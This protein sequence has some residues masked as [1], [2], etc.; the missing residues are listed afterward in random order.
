MKKNTYRKYI[1]I[2]IGACIMLSLF[3]CGKQKYDLKLPSGFESKKTSYA[4]G[5]EVKV[6]YPYLATDTDYSFY[7]DA[8]DMKKGYTDSEGYVFTFTMPERD[9]TFWV[10][11]H[12]SM[13]YEPPVE[14]TENDLMKMVSGDNMLFDYYEATVGTDGG[15]GYT[16][17]VLYSWEGGHDLLLA[18]YTK[19]YGEEEQMRVCRVPESTLYECLAE[20]NRH[21]MKS[22]KDGVAITGE[23]YVVQ[24]ME[25]GNTVRI[26]SDDMP[27][28][29]FSA[30][31]AIEKCCSFTWKV[32]A[33]KGADNG[34]IG[35]IDDPDPFP[36]YTEGVVQPG[37][38]VCPSCGYTNKGPFCSE[39]GTRRPSDTE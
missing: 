28:D 16:E 26:S 8:D 19:S 5:E 24:F 18:R 29:G 23:Y 33:P 22:W 6:T 35:I 2:I 34:H 20:V 1:S 14:Y 32:Y 12:N 25:D 15:D 38:W 11:S 4:A 13:V 36:M 9:V 10:T 21:G 3:G 39:C 37:E 27:E 31:G 30:F 17:Y 7:S